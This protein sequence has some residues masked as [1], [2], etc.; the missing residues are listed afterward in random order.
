MVRSFLFIRLKKF[1]SIKTAAANCN[2][3]EYKS[4]NKCSIS[5]KSFIFAD[6]KKVGVYLNVIKYSSKKIIFKSF[7]LQSLIK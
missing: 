5:Y 1:V 6:I 7:N 3:L 2:L 4:L